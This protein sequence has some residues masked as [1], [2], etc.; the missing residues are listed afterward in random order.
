VWS[1]R[2]LNISCS[3]NVVVLLFLVIM[4][5]MMV[6]VFSEVSSGLVMEWVFL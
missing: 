1:V 3:I 4:L 5:M 2:V 6:L